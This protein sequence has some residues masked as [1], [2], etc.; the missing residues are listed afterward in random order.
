MAVMTERDFRNLVNAGA[1]SSVHV[2][3]RSQQTGDQ[4]DLFPSGWVVHVRLGDVRRGGSSRVIGSKR[5]PVR[6]WKS[7]DTLSAWLLKLGV[8][9]FEVEQA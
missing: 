4:A 9:R 1:V 7:L 8:G 2:A 6:V 3:W 5:E